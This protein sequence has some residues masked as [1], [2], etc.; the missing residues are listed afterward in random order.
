VVRGDDL[1]ETTPRQVW[2]A[3]RLG[4]AVPAYAH[5]PLVLGPDGARLAKRHG[6]VT[7]AD[8]GVRGIGPPAVFGA[9]AA[10]LGLSRP[11]SPV[12]SATDLVAT[13]D[14]GR[15]PVDPW[16]FDPDTLAVNT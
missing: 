8:L 7:L 2:L 9:I 15:M 1:L 12:G 11:G 5:V 14:P 6:D 13:F 4:L 3:R 16:R 10:S